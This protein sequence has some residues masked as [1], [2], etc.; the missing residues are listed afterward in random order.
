LDDYPESFAGIQW[1]VSDAYAV[2]Y[3]ADRAK[4]YSVSGVPTTV[5]D[6]Q[7]RHVGVI[8]DD[9]QMYQLYLGT[10]NTFLATPT[11]VTVELSAE[12]TAAQTYDV[13]ATVG[14]EAGGVGKDVVLHFVQVLDYY[15]ATPDDYYRNCV[16]QH[17]DGGEHTL[18]AGESIDVTVPFTI[19]GASWTNV[20]DA[21]IIVFVQEPGR[22][23]PKIM[24]NA[25]ILNWP[26]ASGSVEGDVD[27]DGDV[28]LSDLS[29]LLG[30][31]GLCLGDDG[32]NDAADFVD[33][34]CIDLSDLALLL[35]N[36]GYGT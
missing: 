25:A 23:Y 15:P 32:Y 35:A 7:T 31:Y 6:G 27:G 13:T 34:D 17:V 30:V 2:A 28:D 1:H 26:F 21:E 18:A 29:A 36:Y 19:S 9:E 22:H 11:D 16:M 4:F 12:E 8:L 33:D 10:M 24:Y 5:F 20:E 14:I 3:A